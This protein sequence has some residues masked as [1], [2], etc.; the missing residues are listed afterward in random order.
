M[1]VQLNNIKTYLKRILKNIV[2]S[3]L[4]E[5]DTVF[6][7][8]NLVRSIPEMMLKEQVA[9]HVTAMI[10]IR[11]ACVE[12]YVHTGN[13]SPAFR[14]QMHFAQRHVYR[15]SN[16][17]VN[18]KTGACCTDAHGF[19]ESYGSLGRWLKAKPIH[20][21]DGRRI[22]VGGPATCINRAGYAHFIMEELPRLL[23]ALKQYPDLRLICPAKMPG[24]MA[25]IYSELKKKDI[26]QYDPIAVPAEY[27]IADDFVFTQAEAYSGFWHKSDIDRLRDTFLMS[28][29][30]PNRLNIY[31][32]RRNSSR[33]FDN[34]AELEQVLSM[35]GFQIVF[36]EKMKFTDQVELFNNAAV[37]VAPHG[38]GLANIVWCSPNTKIIEM[39]TDMVFND[40]FSR[41]SSQ[42][43]CEHYCLWSKDPSGSGNMAID[44]IITLL[45]KMEQQAVL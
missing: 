15:L 45:D 19:L 42:V 4:P 33:S 34:E 25:D 2:F 17:T 44:E 16:V 5:L 38:A 22:A 30:S 1:S 6:S 14:S 31:V 36:L 35:R 18:V 13:P 43:S 27:V 8:E 39:Y 26:L 23:W 11:N 3:V 21:K 12:N 28:T 7:I 24:Y 37:L 9:G 10:V 32:S 29:P 40:C 20:R 41:L